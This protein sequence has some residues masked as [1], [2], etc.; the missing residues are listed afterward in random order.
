MSLLKL[1]QSNSKIEQTLQ[2]YGYYDEEM[3]DENDI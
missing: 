1:I 2:E 3:E